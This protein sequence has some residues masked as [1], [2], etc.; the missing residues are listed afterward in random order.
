MRI[1]RLALAA[2]V[3]LAELLPRA[4]AAADAGTSPKRETPDYDGRPPP[5]ASAGEVAL[6]IPRVLLFPPYVVSE[7]VI[8]RPLG[9][10][11]TLA[12]RNNWANTLLDFFTFGPNNDA[13]IVPTAFFD[14][15]LQPSVGLYFFWNNALLPHNDV[16]A[17]ASYYGNNWL[18]LSVSERVHVG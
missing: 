6:W 17:H 14:F 9:A 3:S 5:P 12:E 1:A 16:R 10:L 2:L 4:A 8:R 11:V 18:A 13:G 15:G 7:F